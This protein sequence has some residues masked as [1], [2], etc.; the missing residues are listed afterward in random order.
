[1][2][3]RKGLLWGVLLVVVVGAGWLGWHGVRTA[4]Q[5]RRAYY[6]VKR[7]E[8]L[9]QTPSVDE[10]PAL[11]NDLIALETHLTDARTAARPFLWLAPRL[12]WLP[13]IG[14]D[15]RAVP[16]LLDMALELAHGGHLA[17]DA[18]GPL[19]AGFNQQTKGDLMAQ[20]LPSLAA[21]GPGLAAANAHLAQAEALRAQVEGP[22]DPRLEVQLA[23]LDRILPLARTAVD[24]M[25]VVPAL[26]GANGPRTYLILAQNNH[27]L[28]ATGGF[29]SGV[30]VVKLDQGKIVDL[31]VSDSYAVDNY[32]KPHPE[33]PVALREQMGAPIL[34]LRD[35][36]WSP[37]FPTSADVARA[38]FLQDRE[39][40]TDGTIAID[41]EAVRL[42]VSALGPLD[43]PGMSGQVTAGNVI[44]RMKQAWAAPATAQGTVEEAGSS[45]WWK[46]RKDFMGELMSAA[47]TRLQGGGKLN[48]MAL[49]SA[50]ITMLRDRHLQIAVDDQA[51]D[52][53]LTQQGWDGGLRPPKGGDFLS[54]ID[55]N[56]GFNKANA[57]V[58]EG[59][60]YN[61]ARS[62]S[63]LTATVSITYTH[64]APVLPADQPCD[65]TPHYG[66]SYDELIRRCYWDY[67][68]VYVPGGSELLSIDGVK[69]SG[70]EQGERGTTVFTGDFAMRPGDTHRVTV[71]YRLPAALANGPYRLE[72]RKQAGT[73]A[74]P[75]RV[76]VGTCN[77]SSDLAEDREFECT[78][79]GAT[80]AQ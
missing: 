63:D 10:F 25:Q 1:M 73:L 35:S 32:N 5:M 58:L 64:T 18:A 57:A 77:W 40:A 16:A 66:N 38:L 23:R 68:R 27:E 75:L 36:N 34:V 45:D 8:A 60:T 56:V 47:L 2:S 39:I 11:R 7:L 53:I 21:A 51:A 54:V 72:V 22:L 43:V 17:V 13:G 59:I 70:T 46:K 14:R 20:L 19:I 74:L 55:S 41:L 44:A 12:G 79:W 31:R 37:D 62:G 71:S 69:T 29:I 42:L 49:A 61:V 30:G 33:P 28:R 76:Q 50:L 78:D 24:G 80:P 52:A 4:I 3:L 65:R 6:D 48:P 26:L 67:L 15:V 9:A